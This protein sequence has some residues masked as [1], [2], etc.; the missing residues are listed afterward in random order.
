MGEKQLNVWIPEEL[1]LYVS[2]RAEQKKCG[3]NM[4]ITELIQKDMASQTG[5]FVEQNNLVVL[6]EVMSEEIRLAS[7]QLRRDLREDRAHET[8]ALTEVLRKHLD[9]LAGLIV[10]SIRNGSIARRLTYTLLSKAH[11]ASFASKA[12][13]DASE[14]AHQELLPKHIVSEGCYSRREDLQAD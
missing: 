7:A 13:E 11:G 12:Y 9:R 3:M 14:K 6:R 10:N 5:E 8:E 2:Q 1:K 4:I